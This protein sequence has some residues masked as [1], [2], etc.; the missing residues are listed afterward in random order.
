[1]TKARHNQDRGQA[2]PKRMTL[3]RVYGAAVSGCRSHLM[4]AVGLNLW[5]KHPP[6]GGARQGSTGDVLITVLLSLVMSGSVPDRATVGWHPNHPLVARTGSDG[7]SPH[8]FVGHRLDSGIG[9][10]LREDEAQADNPRTMFTVGRADF[11]GNRIQGAFRLGG[12]K[13]RLDCSQRSPLLS[14]K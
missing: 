8:R 10:R 14:E 11:A 7:C 13:P 6:D 2:D 1:M 3:G 12:R 5:L 4:R 9:L